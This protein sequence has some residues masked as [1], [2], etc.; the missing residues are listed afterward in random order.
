VEPIFMT[1]RPRRNHSPAF[2]TKVPLAAI[3]GENTLAELAEQFDVNPNCRGLWRRDE[4]RF[5]SAPI[6]VKTLA[7]IN[8]PSSIRAFDPPTFPAGT[9]YSVSP[10]WWH[11]GP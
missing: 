6:D 5:K 1:K 9:L 3:K 4:T 10:F 8:R 2:K 11:K 7:K